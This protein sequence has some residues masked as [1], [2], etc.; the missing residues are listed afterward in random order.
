MAKVETK[1]ILWN[2]PAN[3]KAFITTRIGGYSKDRYASSNMSLDVGDLKSS[4]LKNREDIHRSLQLPS[5]PSWMKQIHG[6]TIQ[7]LNS[8]RKNIIC[9]G[10]YTDQQ[11]VVCAVLSADCLPIMMCDRFGK[12][13]GVLHVGWRG[14]DKDLIQ[15][16]IKR[17]KVEPEDLCVWIGPSI[18]PHNYIVREDVYSKLKKISTKVFKRIDDLHWSLNLSLAA[19]IIFRDARIHNIFVERLCTYE[20]SNLY[21]S[22]RR[23]NVTGR[24]VSLIWKI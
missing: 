19:Q 9:D 22:F 20:S 1:E 3:I 7:Y 17:F 16:F 6:T 10:S 5:E 8:P 14:L 24:M 15:K 13:V 11:G 18:S 23:E 21:Y 2:A 4:V 12:K